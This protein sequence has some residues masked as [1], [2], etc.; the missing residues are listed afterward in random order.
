MPKESAGGVQLQ[1]LLPVVPGAP[2]ERDRRQPDGAGA[3]GDGA[4]AV[5]TDLPVSVASATGPG[6]RAAGKLTRIVETVQGLY[7]A[8]AAGAGGPG[9]KTGS[10]TALQQTSS[11]LRLN[12]HAHVVSLDRAWYEEG[13]ELCWWSLGH[14]K[15]SEVGDVL[16]RTPKRFERYLCR[17]GM[18]RPDEDDGDPDIPGDPEA[19]VAASAVSGCVPGGR[20]ALV[21]GV[22]AARATVAGLRQAAVCLA[23]RVHVARGHSNRGARRGGARDAA[24]LRAAPDYRTGA[25]GASPGRSGADHLEESVQRRDGG[26]GHG[27]AI[28]AM[29][30]G[31]QRATARRAAVRRT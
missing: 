24:A 10:V 2:D 29:P 22:G 30:A 5:G 15:T 21:E 31:H 17:R 4:T 27:P 8:R 18:L 26:G 20:A 13:G 7:A 19:N 14:L 9:A 3:A 23:V 12:P 28:F 25:P 16:E 6:R 11:D 1:G